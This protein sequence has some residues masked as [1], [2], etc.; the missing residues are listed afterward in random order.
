MEK[1][2]TCRDLAVRRFKEHFKSDEV[3]NII[4]DENH[5]IG[6]I[7][8]S[9]T[10]RDGEAL[11]GTLKV[12]CRFL[13]SFKVNLLRI[14][15]DV[16]VKVNGSYYKGYLVKNALS[17]LLGDDSNQVDIWLLESKK[18]RGLEL[19]G[20]GGDNGLVVVSPTIYDRYD[21]IWD[22]DDYTKVFEKVE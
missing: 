6:L 18:K 4:M 7:K 12:R 11:S 22:I 20:L 17:T 14:G 5:Y 2:Y 21:P 19:L 10:L 16:E 3:E 13:G 9:I 1:T 8:G 15:D